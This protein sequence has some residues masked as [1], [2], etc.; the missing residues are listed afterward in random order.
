[1]TTTVATLTKT[2]EWTYWLKVCYPTVEASKERFDLRPSKMVVNSKGRASYRWLLTEMERKHIADLLDIQGLSFHP[3]IIYAR[4]AWLTSN[5]S[6]TQDPRHD[7][8][9]RTSD[10]QSLW[11]SIRI[12]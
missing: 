8:E 3:P 11:Q 7:D 12:R 5:S 10:L 6:R 2:H 1:M 9:P 4:P